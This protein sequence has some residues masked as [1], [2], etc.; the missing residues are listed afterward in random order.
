MVA[1]DN[2]AYRTAGRILL[3]QGLLA[4]L[5]E[6]REREIFDLLVKGKL[7][8]FGNDSRDPAAP[9][10]LLF[11]ALGAPALGAP[12]AR[13]R[14]RCDAQRRAFLEAQAHLDRSGIPLLLFKSTGP[15]PYTSSNVDALVPAGELDRATR[16]LEEA[17]H[18]EMVH[19]WEPNKRLL[20]RFEGS[21]CTVML[22][23][24]TKISWVVLAF[25]DVDALWGS[26][27][28]SIDPGVLHPAPEHLVA[29]LL[30]HSVY[31]S[32]KVHVGDV[33]KVRDAAGGAGFDWDEVVR[34]ARLRSWLPGLAFSLAWY[35]AAEER[36]FGDSLLAA[37]PLAHALPPLSPPQ[38]ERIA[39]SMLQA[40]PARIPKRTSKPFYFRKLLADSPRSPV[41]KAHDLAG[42]A[43]QVA[44]GRLGLRTR[45]G[46]LVCFCGIDG[47]GKSTHADSLRAV[48]GECEIE[49]RRVWMR[50]GY[51][52]LVTWLKARLRGASAAVPEV[53]DA[54]G[55]LR[56]YRQ[57]GT[58]WL[59][60][61]L[62][63]IEQIVQAVFA[64]RVQRWLGR[65]LVAERYVPD[66]LA[67]LSE[68]FG[69]DAFPASLAGRAMRRLCPRPDA[70]VFLDV[71]GDVA[72]ARKSDDW[73]AEVLEARRRRYRA[74]LAAMPSVHVLDAQLPLADVSHQAIEIGLR[75][76]L[77]RIRA[78]NPLSRRRR[79][80]WE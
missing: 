62:V 68:R 11:D 14:E 20:R 24:H 28:R 3:G 40:F 63:A 42:V 41:Q 10:R 37:A 56:V 52:P 19:Y 13:E 8:L 25:S 35:A 29:I 60:G 71:P 57:P 33:W 61:W 45:P 76:V 44:I 43:E 80:G 30:A 55:K 77:G 31:E 21:A 4:G 5:G 72:F 64:V 27:R 48:L 75:T 49:T 2:D 47:S 39:G 69:D 66:T 26:A 59:W 50:G 7:V 46:S 54:Q 12:L 6:A 58:R 18:H 78:W 70:I 79:D 23:L 34:I 16:C 65:T 15:Y 53:G 73:S 74:A 17:G 32:N 38:R 1:F 67:D 22:H 36:L 51:S 9:S